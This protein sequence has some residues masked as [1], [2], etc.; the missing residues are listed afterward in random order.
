MT[1][2]AELVQQGSSNLWLFIPTALLLGALHGLEPGHLS[3]AEQ[4]PATVAV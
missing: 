2:F 1:S 3:T 4:N